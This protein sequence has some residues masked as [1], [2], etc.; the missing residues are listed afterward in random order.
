MTSMRIRMITMVI[1][2][3]LAMC[4]TKAPHVDDAEVYD[5]SADNDYH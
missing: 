5:D 4:A 3:I 1:I 2:L